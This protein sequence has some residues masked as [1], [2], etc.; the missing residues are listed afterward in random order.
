MLALTLAYT[1]LDETASSE[2][3]EYQY[4]GL[5]LTVA[6]ILSFRAGHDKV[7][8]DGST[9]Y[10]VGLVVPPQWIKPVGLTLDWGKLGTSETFSAYTDE[11][12]GTMVSVTATL[13]I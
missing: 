13:A 8:F 5:E 6:R 2:Y 1:W 10:G 11:T 4:Y 3:F 7:L 9:Q 12:P